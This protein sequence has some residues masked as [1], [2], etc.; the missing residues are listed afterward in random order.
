MSLA[1]ATT[2]FFNFVLSFTWPSLQKA[3]KPQGAFSWYAGWN[4]VGTLLTFVFVRET[5][6]KPLE[7]LELQER[8]AS[9]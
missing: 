3:F 8:G 1:T 9:L 6:G 5:K 2:W 4:L 7:E